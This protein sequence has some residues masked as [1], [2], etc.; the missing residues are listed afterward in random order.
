MSQSHILLSFNIN[1]K[2]YLSLR[3][4]LHKIREVQ[5]EILKILRALTKDPTTG[6]SLS[7]GTLSII[8]D[9]QQVE[10]TD[11][12][13]SHLTEALLGGEDP[14]SG[15]SCIPEANGIPVEGPKSSTNEIPP[16]DPESNSNG[17]SLLKAIED[18]DHDT[19]ASLLR[20]PRTSL[21]ERDGK[22]RTP[23][24]LAAHLGKADMINMLLG[25]IVNSPNEDD[26]NPTVAPLPLDEHG[27]TANANAVASHREID[28]TATDKNGRTALHYC[29]EF[30]MR[31]RISFLLDQGVDVNAR[32]DGGFPPAY[33]AAK[34]RHFR[35]TELLLARGATTDFDWPTT[36]AREIEQLRD[37]ASN[38]DDQAA[39]VSPNE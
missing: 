10:D 2:A 37:K 29:A 36:T 26:A 12:L 35:A 6:T 21:K 24:L 38:N 4:Q 17:T 8:T 27:Q 18:G 13:I 39:P 25:E 16:E 19:V 31:D 9:T 33:Y 30:K 32:D 1:E 20:N 28:F 7:T 14:G 22:D 5:E 15:R 34:N 3:V 11:Q 23:L